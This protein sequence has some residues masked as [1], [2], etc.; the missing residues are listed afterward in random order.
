MKKWIKESLLPS[1]VVTKTKNDGV[2]LTFDDGPNP[3]Y[4]PLVLDVLKEY[5]ARAT[6]FLV[7]ENIK[8]YPELTRR[9]ISEGHRVGNHSFSHAEFAEIG[10]KALFHELHACDE[11]LRPALDLGEKPI[12]RTPKGIL[13][14]KVLLF[15]L[16]YQRRIYL[17]NRDPED[18]KATSPEEVLASFVSNPLLSGDVVLL[19]D[20]TPHTVIALREMLR[21]MELAELSAVIL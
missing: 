6:F 10:T 17:W 19:H 16:I 8:K 13:N 14:L 15:S 18:F 5:N 20:K 21:Q 9:I 1:W 11:L 12:I 3:E 7:G 4:T 2:A